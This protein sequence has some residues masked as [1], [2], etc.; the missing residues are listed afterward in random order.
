MFSLEKR[1]GLDVRLLNIWFGCHDLIL[2]EL[3]ARAEA[4]GVTDYKLEA[5]LEAFLYRRF[6]I[7]QGVAER[8]LRLHTLACGH[9]LDRLG[10][11]H[12]G[13]RR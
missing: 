5:Y 2:D 12:L 9:A 1:I 3:V 13:R 6:T 11:V 10:G 8:N 7:C 4:A